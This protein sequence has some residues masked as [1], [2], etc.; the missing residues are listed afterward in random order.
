M[1]ITIEE[2]LKYHAIGMAV[3][4]G[5]GKVERIIKADDEE[6]YYDRK[7]SDSTEEVD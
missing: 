5:N 3:I 7:R 6:A 2:A 4:C 1:D